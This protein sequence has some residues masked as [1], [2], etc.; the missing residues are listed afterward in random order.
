MEYF[1]AAL[2]GI[3]Q[4]LTEFLPISS[5]GHLIILQDIF[6]L[7]PERFGLAFD[8]SLHLGTFLAVSIFFFKDYLKVVSFKNR[9]FL[10]LLAGTIPAGILGLLFES[11]I[12]TTFRQLWV[13]GTSL[14]IFSFVMLLAEY[15]GKKTKSQDKVN[16]LGSLIIGFAQSLALIPGI[17]RSGATISA[18]LFLNLKREEA[19]KFA[20]MLSGPII[21][22]AGTKKFLEVVSYESISQSDINFFIVGIISSFVFGYLTIKYFLKYLSKKSL[23]PFIA[24]RLGLGLLLVFF[25]LL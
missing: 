15:M 16:L 2:A 23:L 5:T 6:K 11:L 17:S 14:I 10:K 21:A 24:Y 25:S 1:I 12:E 18:G 13:V 7:P 8:A 22:G 3:V 4:G 9:L 19:A 20:F